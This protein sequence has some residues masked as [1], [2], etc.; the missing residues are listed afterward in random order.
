[1]SEPPQDWPR[2]EQSRLDL[3]RAVSP[4]VSIDANSEGEDPE[5]ERDEWA[6]LER[7]WD[8]K[9]P[10]LEPEVQGEGEL[11]RQ[12]VVKKPETVSAKDIERHRALGHPVFRD[13]CDHCVRGRAKGTARKKKKARPRAERR[14]ELQG[15]Y[16]TMSSL[17]ET[18]EGILEK[19]E[20][21]VG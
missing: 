10:D 14:P 1:M 19:G 9:Y 13:W 16:M 18:S 12:V 21:G 8:E 4:K 6:E 11:E 20:Q 17:P 2:S 5:G 3:I 7:E 15:D